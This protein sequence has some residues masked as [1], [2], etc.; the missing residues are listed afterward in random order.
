LKE[1][2]PDIE[3]IVLTG[4]ATLE[5]TIEA[6]RRGA[7]DF[8]GKPL[9]VAELLA[10]V[11]RALEKRRRKAA[12]P[13]FHASRPLLGTLDGEQLIPEI[14]AVAQRTLRAS[15][16]ALVQAAAE[17]TGQRVHFSPDHGVFTSA[18]AERLAEVALRAG[19]PVHRISFAGESGGRSDEGHPAGSALA[20]PL[21][22]RNTLVGAL[23]L[24]R[25]EGLAHFS[26]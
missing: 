24:W 5:S 19:E 18:A 7:C 8:L 9:E 12:L 25:A 10:A 16:A 23:V 6:L 26:W 2:D 11:R 15:G 17:K 4:Y 3:V 1:V 14:L 20:Y 13:V 21:E 22:A